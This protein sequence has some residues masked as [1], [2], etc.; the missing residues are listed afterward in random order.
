[1]TF[2]NFQEVQEWFEKHIK[3]S[4]TVVETLGIGS[5][6]YSIEGFLTKPPQAGHRYV[7]IDG[8]TVWASSIEVFD[9]EKMRSAQ[10]IGEIFFEELQREIN[11]EV[12]REIYDL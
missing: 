10:E 2:D 5:T 3:V 11:R 6:I 9:P 8:K 4:V 7:T 1:M 12:I